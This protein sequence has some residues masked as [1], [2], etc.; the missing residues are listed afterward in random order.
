MRR[1]AIAIAVRGLVMP[2]SRPQKAVMAAMV[3]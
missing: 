2:A 1:P 3:A